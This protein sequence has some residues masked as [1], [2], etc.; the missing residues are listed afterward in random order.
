MVSVSGGRMK[1]RTCVVTGASRGLGRA[2]AE[3]FAAEGARVVGI[4][5][6]DP[7]D[8]DAEIGHLRVDVSQEAEVERAFAEVAQRHGGLDVLVNNAAVQHEAPFLD[9]TVDDFERV[10]GV[11]LRGTFLCM[12]AA[13]G[14]MVAR[15]SGAIVNVSSIL[16]HVGDPLLP[17]YCA[18]KAG[19]LG[20]TRS[21]AVAYGAEG[22]R[23]TAICP[24]DIDTELN[25]TYFE[26][27]PD[28]AAFRSR[29]EG[30]YPARR[31]ATTDEVARAV[32]FLASD[33]ASFV[34]GSSLIVD[35]GILARPYQV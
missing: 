35:G 27:Q 22:V 17:V 30:E 15:R 21:A 6:L 23:V 19:I 13:L 5:L 26:S 8:G 7:P 14:P 29:I 16:G 33:D 28:P 18:T 31:I 32:L 2:I 25:A 4:D 20:L 3:S 12:R 24:A 10:V 11:N 9:Q 34:T 1:E